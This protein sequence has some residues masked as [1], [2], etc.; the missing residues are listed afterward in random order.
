MTE[1]D[2]KQ[3][4]IAIADRMNDAIAAKKLR[5]LRKIAD[6]CHAEAFAIVKELEATQDCERGMREKALKLF[7]D[8]RMGRPITLSFE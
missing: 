7:M 6:E 1:A 8:V 5:A 3:R 4:M 2:I